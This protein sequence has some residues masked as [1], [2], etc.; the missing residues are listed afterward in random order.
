MKAR[1]ILIV[2]LV[3]ALLGGGVSS[4]MAAV[5]IRL[6]HVDPPDVF[7][8]KKGAVGVTFKNLVEAEDPSVSVKLFPSG[9]LGGDRELTEATKLGTLQMS[10]VPLGNSGY[11][12]EAQV[13]DIPYLFDSAPVAWKVI[14]G[15]FG[16]ELAEECLKKTGMRVLAYDEIGFR[17]FTSSKTPIRSP[18]DMKGL[19]IRVME[20]PVYVNLIKSLGAAATPIPWP[21]T[22][23][24]LQ[25]GV[26]D[27]Q[28]NPVSVILQNK[29]YEVQK[30]LTLDGHTYGADFMLINDKFYQSLPKETQSM[31]RRAAIVAAWAGRSVQQIN[32][33][34]GVSQLKEKGMQVYKPTRKEMASFREATQKPVIEYIE[35]QAGRPWIDKVMKAAQE[36]EADLAR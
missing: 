3:A 6:A 19:K 20:S 9:Q 22:Y 18:A 15:W 2:G 35:K 23:T 26:V 10:L 29:L 28:E 24:A 16:K 5:E 12:K 17:N 4:T 11:C 30:Y 8:S 21:E 36:A 14:D 25:Q 13:F 33:A 27:G 31:L 32:S 7:V 1:I 34:I